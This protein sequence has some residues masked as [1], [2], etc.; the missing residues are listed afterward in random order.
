MKI[1]KNLILAALLL[2]SPIEAQAAITFVQNAT[3]QASSGDTVSATIS[4]TTAGHLLVA[5]VYS[6][7]NNN[8]LAPTGVTDSASHTWTK[9]T[10]SDSAASDGGGFSD[11]WYYPN[12]T[13]GVT[14]VTATFSYAAGG[15]DGFN[16]SVYEFAGAAVSSPLETGNAATTV[17][18]NAATSTSG[19]AAITTSTSGDV[20]VS[21]IFLSH[22]AVAS[23]PTV[24]SMTSPYTLEGN[25][26]HAVTGGTAFADGYNI[27]TT[28][29]TSQAAQF[30]GTLLGDG[31]SYMASTAAAFEPVSTPSGG[32]LWFGQ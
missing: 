1:F 23:Y 16:I 5:V 24:T 27:T 10:G 25:I 30:N 6:N 11:I 13:S 20:I 29:V 22:R 2:L 12:T 18:S 17:Q 32:V 4:S 26:T 14:S 3:G 19:T 9:A 21:G 31:S 28:T 15:T 7:G 8:D